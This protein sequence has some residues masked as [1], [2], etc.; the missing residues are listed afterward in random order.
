MAVSKR[1]LG[2]GLSNLIPVNEGPEKTETKVVEKIVEKKVLLFII[3]LMLM[4]LEL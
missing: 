2:K 3:H 4:A 1:G